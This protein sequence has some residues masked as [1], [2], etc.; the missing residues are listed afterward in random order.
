[1]AFIVFH[2]SS[3]MDTSVQHKADECT[4]PYGY[5]R[6][7]NIRLQHMMNSK[8]AFVLNI[9]FLSFPVW[10]LKF[11]GAIIHLLSYLVNR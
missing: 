10:L 9:A 4:W 11:D 8:E 3:E 1:M 2:T 5:A 7:N 6:E